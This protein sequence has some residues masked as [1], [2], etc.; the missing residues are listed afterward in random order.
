MILLL[1]RKNKSGI[2]AKIADLGL[3]C[4]LAAGTPL[5]LTCGTPGYMAPEVMQGRGYDE[6]A[7][8]YSCGVLLYFM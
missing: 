1:H 8:I 4:R 7:D 5:D 3:A 6:K 2:C